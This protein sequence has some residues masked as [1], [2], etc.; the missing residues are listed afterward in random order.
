MAEALIPFNE[1]AA[2]WVKETGEELWVAAIYLPEAYDT[3]AKCVAWEE[4]EHP[5]KAYVTREELDDA[6][7]RKLMADYE[8]KYDL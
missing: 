3:C 6:I 5:A 2:E 4:H 8:A 1:A 7:E